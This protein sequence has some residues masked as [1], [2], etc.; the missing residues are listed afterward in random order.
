V[1]FDVEGSPEG[2]RP[3]VIYYNAFDADLFDS[4]AQRDASP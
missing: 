4:F 3:G 2:S 1:A